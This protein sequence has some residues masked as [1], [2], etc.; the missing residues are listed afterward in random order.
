L[1]GHTGG[2]NSAVFS[3]D[4]NSLLSV[5]DDRTARIW[6][7]YQGN[8]LLGHTSAVTFAAVSPD[9]KLL[10]TTGGDGTGYIWDPTTGKQLAALRGHTS[11]VTRAAFSPDSK[12]VATAGADGTVRTWDP[13][14]GASRLVLGSTSDGAVNDFAFSPDGKLFVVAQDCARGQDATTCT[15]KPRVYEVSTGELAFEGPAHTRGVASVRF[16]PDGASI[17]SAAKNNSA[18][19]W[20]SQNGNVLVKVQG[21]LPRNLGAAGTAE[22]S[23]DGKR[24]LTLSVVDGVP[25]VWDA[26][27]G[28]K[29]F[30]LRGHQDKVTSAVFSPDGTKIL[31]GSDD[32]TARVWDA[33]TG[34]IL[35]ELKGHI[36][37]VNTVAFS[38]NGK[39]VLTSSDDYTARL[40]DAETGKTWRVLRDHTKPLTNALFSPDGRWLVTTSNDTTAQIFPCDICGSLDQLLTLARARVTRELSCEERQTYLHEPTECAG[41]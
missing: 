41:R 15:S 20:D 10:V 6:N 25:Q 24:I 18:I 7:V 30:E 9:G 22:L 5:S 38:P 2:V 23:A 31:T 11:P 3:P 19:L 13:F 39:L 1:R 37:G 21:T 12:I 33:S 4:G 28:N 29:L 17:L 40:W 27:T 32:N 14:T 16:S 26:V 8:P 35:Q 34:G 36:Y